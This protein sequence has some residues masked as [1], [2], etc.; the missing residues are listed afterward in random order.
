MP[1]QPTWNNPYLTHNP[2]Q[3]M[4]QNQTVPQY[5]QQYQQSYQQPVN[6][7]TQVNGPQSALQI[8]LPPNSISNPL[9]DS[10]FDGKKGVFYI[11]STDG[12]G[13][14]SLEAFDF[15]PHVEQ[16]PQVDNS[17]FVS[18]SEFDE[19]SMR[20]NVILGALNNGIHGPVQATGTP[21]NGDEGQ[22]VDAPTDDAR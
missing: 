19:L 20:V 16:Q 22:N 13:S 3:S 21:T 17:Q 2:Y 1:Y 18:R 5:Q 9:I 14:K 11:V 7:I 8:S 15:S 12:T 10:S 6:G 4:M